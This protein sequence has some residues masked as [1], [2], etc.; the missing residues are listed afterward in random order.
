MT[1]SKKSAVKLIVLKEKSL[2]TLEELDK[3]YL[4]ALK[5]LNLADDLSRGADWVNEYLTDK[6][7]TL[8]H[9]QK[10]IP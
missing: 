10:Y 3:F 8:K 5:E 2:K 6:D 4:E 1:I 9:L 7:V